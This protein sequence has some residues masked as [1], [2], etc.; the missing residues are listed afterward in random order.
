MYYAAFKFRRLELIWETLGRIVSYLFMTAII[1]LLAILGPILASGI[2]NDIF[3]GKYASLQIV[4]S[5]LPYLRAERPFRRD[6]AAVRPQPVA[7][8]HAAVVHSHGEGQG[9]PDH[10]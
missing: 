9:R 10:R 4:T 1:A 8:L 7:R 2:I 5:I 3:G 6:Y